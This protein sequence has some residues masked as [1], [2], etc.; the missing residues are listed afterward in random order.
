MDIF[1]SILVTLLGLILIVKGADIF[2]DAA[3]WVARTAHI[4]EL[5]IGATI[6]SIGTTLPELISA[7]TSVGIGISSGTPSDFNALAVGDAVGSMLCN[8]GLIAGL[9]TLI[10]PNKCVEK[11][12][13]LKA[14]YLL[15]ISI[16]LAVFII[17]GSHISVIE[18][19]ILLI[20]F[21]GFLALNLLGSKDKPPVAAIT[22]QTKPE[23][24]WWTQIV[25]FV[26]GALA[27]AGGAYMMVNGCEKIC[28]VLGVPA[29]IV[30]I[31]V[32]AIGTSLP[33]LVTSL[34]AIRKG[35]ANLG[36]GNIIGANTVNATLLLGSISCVTGG[37]GIDTFTAIAATGAMIAV[38]LILVVPTMIT[39]KTS[40]L[41]GAAM[42]AVYLGLMVTNVIYIL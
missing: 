4:S 42:M 6:V 30:G 33:E 31:S 28:T 2:V 21:I 5:V 26:I 41:Q 37:L 32:V 16:L 8:I 25:Q 24:K 1:L 11:G 22:V 38:T 12:F 35:N 23:G 36:L 27:V 14:G 13:A 19:V 29:Q 15:I 9:C 39:S 7:L 34:N 10:R 17:T 3:V 20:A 40:R 18:G